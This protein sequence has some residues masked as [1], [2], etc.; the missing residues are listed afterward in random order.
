[1]AFSSKDCIYIP[2]SDDSSLEEE[3]NPSLASQA[4]RKLEDES[5]TPTYNKELE[6]FHFIEHKNKRRPIPFRRKRKFRGNR[7]TK[8][9]VVQSQPL[10]LN[11]LK[12]FKKYQLQHPQTSKFRNRL[13][14]QS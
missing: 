14:N 10:C 2:P 11:R 3:M 7:N 9:F 8:K 5:S 12:S 13:H 4:S 6:A 1:M